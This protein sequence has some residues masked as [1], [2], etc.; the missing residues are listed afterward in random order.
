VGVGAAVVAAPLVAPPPA[1]AVAADPRREVTFARALSSVVARTAPWV[2]GGIGLAGLIEVYVPAGALAGVRPWGV[3]LG[4]AALAGP[5]YVCATGVTLVAA[6]LVHKGLSAG[7]ALVLL[8]VAPAVSASTVR[9][10][11]ARIGGRALGA[12]LGAAS[13]G[14]VASGLVVDALLPAPVLPSVGDEPIGPLAWSSMAV[15]GAAFVGLLLRGGPSGFVAP[16]QHPDH[17]GGAT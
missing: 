10:L 8:F 3:W 9:A 11:Y 7:G 14:A 12:A 5:I 1:A 2:L 16:I 6:A 17:D 4:A 15:V 13:L